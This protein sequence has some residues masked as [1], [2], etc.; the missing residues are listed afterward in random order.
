MPP[1]EITLTFGSERKD[2]YSGGFWLKKAY[3]RK[4]LAFL[5]TV[6]AERVI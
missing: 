6:T 2:K 5:H 1:D 4:N 3:G